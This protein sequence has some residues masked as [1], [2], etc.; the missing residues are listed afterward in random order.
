MFGI[1]DFYLM[2]VNSP[3]EPLF[4]SLCAENVVHKW[5]P[6]FQLVGGYIEPFYY[7]SE[8]IGIFEKRFVG[9]LPAPYH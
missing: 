4:Y 1:A 8:Y 2:Q 9:I 7:I 6:S 3:S 5:R